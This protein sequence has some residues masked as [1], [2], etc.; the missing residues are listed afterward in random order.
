MAFIFT[1]EVCLLHSWTGTAD[2]MTFA[3]LKA[4]VKTMLSAVRC[5][6]GTFTLLELTKVIQVHLQ[7][8]NTFH[9]AGV[10]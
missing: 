10:N 8:K 5:Q 2:K 1:D 6:Y 7:D 9:S 4:V 3:N